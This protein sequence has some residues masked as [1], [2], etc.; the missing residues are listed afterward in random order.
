M[1]IFG[2]CVS[3]ETFEITKLIAVATSFFFFIS[4]L[5]SNDAFSASTTPYHQ[6]RFCDTNSHQNE[7]ELEYHSSNVKSIIFASLFQLKSYS[8]D[9]AKGRKLG[10]RFNELE[11]RIMLFGKGNNHLSGHFFNVC[12]SLNSMI[13]SIDCKSLKWWKRILNQHIWSYV[14]GKYWFNM[15][16]FQ[17]ISKGTET[18]LKLQ[19]NLIWLNP[20]I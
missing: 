10:L 17:K 3:W 19:Q 16:P 1:L 12:L 8:K 11:I 4:N 18:Q 13:S 5:R 9:K 20:K 15:Q 2:V 6:Y 14:P 7:P